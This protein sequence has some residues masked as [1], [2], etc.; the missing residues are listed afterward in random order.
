MYNKYPWFLCCIRKDFIIMKHLNFEERETIESLLK[1]NHTFT[2]IGEQI[3]KH[4][5]TVAQEILNH[6]IE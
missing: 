1:E 4:R 6:R 3:G 5:T 2:F